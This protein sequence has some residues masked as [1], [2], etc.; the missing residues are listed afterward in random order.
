MLRFTKKNITRRGFTIVEL[1]VVI[2]VIAILAGILVPTFASIVEDAKQ[3]ELKIDLDTAYTEFAA[4]CGFRDEPVQ[5]MD[6]Y[7]FVAES[8]LQFSSATVSVKADG[9]R[10][11]GVD[12]NDVSTVARSSIDTSSST[13]I[14]GPFNGYYLLGAGMA[15]SW[16]GSGSET[17]PFLITGYE[18]LRA[19]AERVAR[20]ETFSGKFFRLEDDLFIANSSWLPI[21]GFFSPTQPDTTGKAVFSGTFDGNGCC[22]SLA[23]GNVSQDGY[24]LFGY[25]SGATVK[26]LKVGGHINVGANAGGVIGTANNTTVQNCHNTTRVEGDHHV[27]GIVGNA[28]GTTKI[29]GCAND[30][31]VI[32]YDTASD[33]AVGGIVGEAASGVTVQ[34]CTNRGS[35][36]AMGGTVGGIAG[37]AKGTVAYCV[38]DGAVEAKGYAASQVSGGKDSLAGG[39]VGWGAGTAKVDRCGNTGNVTAANRSAGGIA[40]ADATVTN[41]ANVGNI[42]AGSHVGGIMGTTS[43]TACTVTNV[44]NGGTVAAKGENN[45]GTYTGPAGGIVGKVSFTSQYTVTLAVSGGQVHYRKGVSGASSNEI[46]MIV[47]SANGKVALTNNYLS[48]SNGVYIGTGAATGT[49][50]GKNSGISGNAALLTDQS[51]LAATMNGLVGSNQRWTTE[52]GFFKNLYVPILTHEVIFTQT[53]LGSGFVSV[54]RLDTS[55]TGASTVYAAFPIKTISNQQGEQLIFDCW[56]DDISASSLDAGDKVKLEYDVIF[57]WFGDPYN[58]PM[59]PLPFE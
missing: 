58:G 39:I 38:N 48:V 59:K 11:N 34:D 10:W 7:V 50:V 24:C 52:A 57:S 17:D 42:T 25:T 19:V 35:I 30:G 28:T 15:L 55:F 3:R 18:E 14:Y 4:D 37:I 9:Y 27:G 40:G 46:G 41:G 45:S 36:T 22:I 29:L 56:Y 31:T 33:N 21:G 26:N 16:S 49:A 2:A 1:V 8:D 20:G 13:A 44:M 6:Q 47:G 54:N 53:Q 32:A 51:S 12:S 23:Y 43:K 5:N